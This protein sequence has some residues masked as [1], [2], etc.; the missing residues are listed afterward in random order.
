MSLVQIRPYFRARLNA[1]AYV[2]WKDG[3]NFQNI[4]STLLNRSYHIE[5]IS[6]S[7][8]SLNQQDQVINQEVS[9]RVFFKGYRNPQDAIDSAMSS[10]QEILVSCLA[11]SNRLTQGF[12]NVLF[13]SMQLEPLADSNDNAVILSL[14]FTVLVIISPGQ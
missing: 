11:P 1:L 6:G 14:T 2:E 7:G 3:F 4:P 13:S 9:V 8:V 12:K 5:T 10:Y